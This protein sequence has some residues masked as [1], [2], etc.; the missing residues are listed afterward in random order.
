MIFGK[1]LF[2]V[3]Y[4]QGIEKMKI[5]TILNIIPKIIATISI[6]LIIKE[7]SDYIYVPLI[8]SIGFIVGGLLAFFIA[9]KDIKLFV[10]SH[11]YI[12]KIYKDSSVL[13]ISNLSTTLFTSINILI[14]GIFTNDYIVG[15]YSS[16]ERLISAMKNL[17]V[18][19]YQGIFPW[20]SKKNHIE[21]KNIIKRLFIYIFIL[22][23]IIFIILVIFSN[24][25]LGFIYNKNQDILNYVNIFKI[26]SFIIVASALN[27]LFN[28]LYLSAIKA[29]KIRLKIFLYVGMISTIFSLFFTYLY[30]I[31]GISISFLF[32]ETLLLLY[33]LYYYSKKG[34][35]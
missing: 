21:I 28:Y 2:P 12:I 3:W 31:Y 11:K 30:G 27:M 8:N 9:F 23:F 1:F 19:I 18:P 24:E 5:I 16:I 17:F 20:L 35:H 15:I 13:F 34:E 25:I 22:S 6:F 33:G 4:F 14:L 26:L 10:P 29:Y 32:S 7:E